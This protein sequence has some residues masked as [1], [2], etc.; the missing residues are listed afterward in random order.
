MFLP[1]SRG[2]NRPRSSSSADF[3]LVMDLLKPQITNY[4]ITWG[5][6]MLNWP[7]AKIY[8]E[9]FSSSIPSLR[10]IPPSLSWVENLAFSTMVTEAADYSDFLN[11]FSPQ[12]N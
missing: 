10:R 11:L 4:R 7:A 9:I 2:Q 6:P 8:S 12:L 3:N 1:G 5:G